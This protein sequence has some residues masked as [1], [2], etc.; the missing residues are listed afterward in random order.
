[1]LKDKGIQTTVLSYDKMSDLVDTVKILK[2]V[3]E[4]TNNN[5]EGIERALLQNGM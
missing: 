4:K 2:V 3:S 5:I 1:M